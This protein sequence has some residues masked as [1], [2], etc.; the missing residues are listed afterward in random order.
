MSRRGCTSSPQ[1][2]RIAV[3]V[4]GTTPGGAW[5]LPIRIQ[6]LA[7]AHKLLKLHVYQGR[8]LGARDGDCCAGHSPR[9]KLMAQAECEMYRAL[10]RC[11]AH[12]TGWV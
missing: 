9:V 4:L 11:V 7:G 6:L 8:P 10:S 1:E 2:R 3:A 5:L 12:G